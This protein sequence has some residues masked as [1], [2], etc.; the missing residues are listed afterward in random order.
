[1]SETGNTRAS[2]LLRVRNGADR[3]AWQEFVDLYAPLLYRFACK[4]RLQD[5]DA[6]DIG[7][8]RSRLS[9][10]SSERATRHILDGA[11]ISSSGAS[12]EVWAETA[13]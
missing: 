1:M 4:Q 9:I 7:Q 11:V 13:G 8:D 12:G 2:L 10:R 3:E 5:A 6:A